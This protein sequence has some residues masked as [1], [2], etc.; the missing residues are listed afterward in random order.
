MD[1][2]S[3]LLIAILFSSLAAAARE[4][5]SPA[6]SSPALSQDQIRQMIRQAA[7]KDMENDKRARDYTYIEREEKRARSM[8]AAG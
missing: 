1:T 6:T 7:D 5:Q 4:N 3:L 2:S 8:A